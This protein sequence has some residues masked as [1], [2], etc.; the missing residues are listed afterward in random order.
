M[1]TENNKHIFINCPYDKDYEKIFEAVVFCA[2]YCGYNPR[3]ALDHSDAASTR[4]DKILNMI[5]ESRLAIHDISRTELDTEHNLPRFNMPYEFGIFVS[6]RHFGG[7]PHKNKTCLVLDKEP[8][9]Y[10]KF[11]SDIAGSDIFSHNQSPDIAIKQIRKWLALD[12][13]NTFKQIVPSDFVI[14]E[15]FKEFIKEL[16]SACLQLKIERDELILNDYIEYLRFVAAF[17]K[18]KSN[19]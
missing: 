1:I 5:K 16:P 2:V 9:R 10:Q 18:S 4:F 12:A 6:A 13:N 19:V 17:V 8:R 3:C 14:N 7:E 15:S 11:I